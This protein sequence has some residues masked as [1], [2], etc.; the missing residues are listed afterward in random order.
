MAQLTVGD[1]IADRRAAE[2]GC[3]CDLPSCVPELLSYRRR[4][5]DEFEQLRCTTFDEPFRRVWINR[6]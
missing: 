5:E 2:L 1:T 3:A 4:G 6:P